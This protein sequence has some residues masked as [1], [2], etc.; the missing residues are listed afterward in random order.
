M[1]LSYE[2]RVVMTRHGLRPL[3]GGGRGY[4]R[5]PAAS[6]EQARRFVAEEKADGF[7]SWVE[8]RQVSDWE[9]I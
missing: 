3:R 7:R 5:I 4:P 2:Y 6:E 1:R 9:K 8:R